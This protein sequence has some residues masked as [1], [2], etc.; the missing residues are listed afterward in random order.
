MP[1]ASRP[2]SPASSSGY[3]GTAPGAGHRPLRERDG[4]LEG[5]GWTPKGLGM[6]WCCHRH[7]CGDIPSHGDI[8][9]SAMGTTAIPMGTPHAQPCRGYPNPCTGW[10]QHTV[11]GS[12][13]PGPGSPCAGTGSGSD[14]PAPAEQ[15]PGGWQHPAPAARHL[16][17]GA[18]GGCHHVCRR[19]GGS[20]TAAAGMWPWRP[21]V[22]AAGS[23]PGM[24]PT[25]G[26]K[27]SAGARAD[28]STWHVL[29]P[30][31]PRQC[32]LPD[33][34]VAPSTGDNCC[35]AHPH[36]QKGGDRVGRGLWG[37]RTRRTGCAG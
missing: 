33:F 30:H 10:E 34:A 4:P 7:P 19:M 31:A 23:S 21:R 20:S 12:P 35:N 15:P 2:S 36:A 37:G 22:G 6:A 13:T 14:P 27:G 16:N 11:W 17:L 25:P 8:P 24:I 26:T 28:P 3:P 9:N 5:L 18:S 1:L 32:H 29:F